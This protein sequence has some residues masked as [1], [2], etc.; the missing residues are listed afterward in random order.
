MFA[1][2]LILGGRKSEPTIHK[3]G[4][5]Q[6]CE[7]RKDPADAAGVK[8]PKAEARAQNYGGNEKAGDDEE[9]VDTD[10]PPGEPKWKGMKYEHGEHRY[11]AQSIH[12][13][14]VLEAGSHGN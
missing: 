12:I 5:K 6:E 7:R 11:A 9:H 14:P 4:A 3:T 8:D 2:L 13:R 10:E 1:D